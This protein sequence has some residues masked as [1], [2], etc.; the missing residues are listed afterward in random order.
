MA[1]PILFEDRQFPLAE[2]ELAS[3]EVR[4]VTVDQLAFVHPCD[5]YLPILE[6]R[7]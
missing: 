4:L 7:I 5:S 6:E 2:D 1:P 3:L